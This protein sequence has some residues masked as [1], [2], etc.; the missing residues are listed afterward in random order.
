MSFFS[1]GCAT[2]PK[3]APQLLG[4]AGGI[5][6][7]VQRG[8]TLWGIGRVYHIGP[9]RIATLNRLPDPSKLAVGQL[10]Y[11]PT[12]MDK[13]HPQK[14]SD[15]AL[16]LTFSWPVPGRITS[17]FGGQ[18]L[19]GRNKGINIQGKE[20]E[21]VLSSERG[22]VAFAGEKVKGFGKTIIL[23]HGNHIQSLYAHNKELLVQE[24][25]RVERRQ[26]IAHLGKTGRVKI[27]TL[28]FEIRRYSRPQNPLRYLK[29]GRL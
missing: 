12:G 8:E 18:T 29:E 27:P 19:Y 26:P 21:T 13:P 7:T 25:D 28:H 22:V 4:R 15:S 5:Y 11:I 16:P 23:D 6:H 20:G 17:H 9:E 3:E 10:L 2:P 14:H 24:G 1:K